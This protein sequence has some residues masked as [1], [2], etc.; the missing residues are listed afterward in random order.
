MKGLST[1]EALKKI[2][3]QGYN[4]LNTSYSKNILQI[5]LE[6]FKEPMFILLISCGALYLVLGDNTEGIIML[7]WVFVIIFIT[8]YQHQ[9]TEKALEALKKLSSP[10]ALVIR[11]GKEIKIAGREVVTDDIVLLNEGDRIP[12][13]GVLLE[14]NNLSIDE[15]ML[16]GESVP[17][18]KTN[19][20][21]TSA[22]SLVFSG[23][24]IVQGSGIMQVTSI[25]AN[26]EFGK[27]GKSLQLIEQD[28]TKLQKEMKI[29]IRN[30]FIIGVVLSVVV[31]IAYYFT[32]GNF[33]QAILNGLSATMAILPEEFPVV[34]TVFL[35]IGSWRLSQQN[36]L[37]RKPSA[38]ETLGSATV[39]CS[40]KTGTI[41]QNK[42]EIVSL[43][44]KDTLYNKSTFQ[45]NSNSVQDILQIA[46]FA[47]QKN[48]I[49]PM[50]KAIGFSY[51]TYVPKEELSY[52]LVKEY[53]LS[54][55]LFAMTRVLKSTDSNYL[56]CCK[57]APEAILTL[58]KL[59]D[60]EQHKL[61]AHVQKMAELGQRVLGVA[62][63][64]WS[65]SNLPETQQAFDFEFI[66]FVGFE[67]PIRPEVPQAIKECYAAGIKVI[68][69]T[70]DYPSTAKSI[71]QQAGMNVSDLILTGS[72]LK[73]MSD[74]ELKEKIESVNI[75]ARI[76]PE[77]KLQIIKAFKA[78]GEVV[79]MTGDGVN[80]APALKAAD[81]GIAMG[82]K[83]TD[84]ARESASLVL[85]D[86]NFSSIVSAIRS[87]RKIFDNL[88]KAMAYII[89]IH[90]P[91]IGLTLLPAFFPELPIL[92]MPLHIVFMELIIDPV[93]S[94]AFESEKEE[95]GIMNRPPR[96]PNMLFFGM[97]KILQSASM[98]LLL[99]AMVIAVY[100][101]S[102]QEGHTDGEIRAIAFSSLII[103]NIFLIMTTLSK[104]RNAISV[105]FEKNIALLIII[106]A[107]SGLMLF[108]ITI[109]YLQAIFSF[110][111]PGFKHFIIS[112]IGA[113]IVLL[114]LEIIKF[115]KLKF[116]TKGF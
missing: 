41:T 107:A 1:E 32:R 4:E 110:E 72:D 60:S 21:D 79:A 97:K 56:V 81:I 44:A 87:G 23:T 66:G 19:K 73:N 100:F 13:D 114:T 101:I 16:T 75:F 71:A 93:C 99:L 55:H 42:M 109:P 36:V 24:L 70:G 48:T 51:E 113:S 28:Q 52:D 40:D 85:L 35:A 91:I 74:A 17:V 83:G 50:E 49:D 115:S 34:L 31:V 80:D 15:S 29:L 76:V 7:C 8:F 65:N 88:Q 9:K 102:I 62:K 43:F 3:T 84:V 10:R 98:G 95:L 68:M 94:I 11:D 69:I 106:I 104:T 92:L 77:Q 89:A 67:D 111:A 5:A 105:L 2:Q 20:T 26:T 58:C 22:S 18:L 82:G 57:G 46:F 108:I 53:P 78:N 45:Q 90:I 37:T 63:A 30:L 25:G 38:I 116:G 14:S 47:S 103:G 54:K 39:L 27:I 86:D 96:D 33:I 61:L 112:I 64:T 12:A 59:S 6:V